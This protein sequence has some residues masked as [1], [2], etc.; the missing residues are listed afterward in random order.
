MFATKCNIS[1][2]ITAIKTTVHGREKQ[3]TFEGLR[4]NLNDGQNMC[5]T[6]IWPTPSEKCKQI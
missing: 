1:L 2:Q 5:S 3:I 4:E 6:D